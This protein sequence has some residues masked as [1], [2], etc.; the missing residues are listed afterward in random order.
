MEQ[1]MTHARSADQPAEGMM[2]V[3]Q[4]GVHWMF[5]R[6]DDDAWQW[7]SCSLNAAR[8]GCSTLRFPTLLACIADASK[9]GFSA[10]FSGVDEPAALDAA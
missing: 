1:L 3:Q 5:F 6:D 4:S 7:S 2:I 10:Q 8:T 9:H